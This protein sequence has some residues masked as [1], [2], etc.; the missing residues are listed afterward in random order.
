[1]QAIQSHF[2][3]L[4]IKYYIELLPIYF[5]FTVIMKSVFVASNNPP[6]LFSS[7]F[8]PDIYPVHTNNHHS[9]SSDMFQI[10]YTLKI[11]SGPRQVKIVLKMK[12]E[13]DVLNRMYYG[14]FRNSIRMCL[15]AF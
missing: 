6:L 13:E 2:Y 9:F 15:K 1:M 7:I 4:D 3:R 5:N 8:L 10:V 14:T 12:E 11:F